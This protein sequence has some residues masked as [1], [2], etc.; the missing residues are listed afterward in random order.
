[1]SILLEYIIVFTLVAILN[2]FTIKFNKN[3]SPKDSLIPEL[4]YLKKVY[5]ISISNIDKDIFSK[6]VI[7]L[8]SFIITTIYIILIYLLNTWVLRIIVGIVLLILM[9]I[10]CYG[11][12]GRYYM[13]KE[14]R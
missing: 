9:I 8:N 2:S 14:G 13:K 11:L 7:L 3:N 1:M 5:K 6:V 10:I 4:I 12:L